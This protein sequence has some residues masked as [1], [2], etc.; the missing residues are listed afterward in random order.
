MHNETINQQLLEIKCVYCVVVLIYVE[1]HTI[2]TGGVGTNDG[3]NSGNKIARFT[4]HS[5]DYTLYRVDTTTVGSQS[6]HYNGYI[7]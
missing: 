1:L 6:T 3:E 5:R 2:H 4:G 7:V